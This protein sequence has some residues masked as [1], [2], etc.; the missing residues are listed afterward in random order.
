MAG[1]EQLGTGLTAGGGLPWGDWLSNLYKPRTPALASQTLPPQP[2]PGFQ[3]YGQLPP[4]NAPQDQVN[5]PFGEVKPYQPPPSEAAGDLAASFLRSM[6]MDNYNAAA[7]GRGASNVLLNSPLT[8]VPVGAADFRHHEQTGDK[9][10]AAISAMGV[11]PGGKMLGKAAGEAGSMGLQAFREGAQAFTPLGKSGVPARAAGALPPSTARASLPVETLRPAD[12]V[13]SPAESL[14]TAAKEA[15]TG[16]APAI[17]A[18]TLRDKPLDEAIQIASTEQHLIPKPEGGYVG[19][20]YNVRDTNDIANMRN[21]FDEAVR[22]GASIKGDQWY[23]L[24]RELVEDIAPN[25]PLQ[26][27]QLAQALGL[28]SA[29]AT[30]NTNL[31]FTIQARNAYQVGS[32]AS[33]VRTGAQA[34]KYNTARDTGGDIPLGK[35]TEIYGINLDPNQPWTTTGTNDIWHARAFG[36][37]NPKGKP[38]DSALSAQHHAFLDAETVLAVKRANEM[39]LG[40]R[41]DWTAPEI[42]AASWVGRKAQGLLG[43]KRTPDMPSALA[44]AAQGYTEA[45]P[46]YTAYGTA[47]ATPGKGIGHLESVASGPA[48]LRERFAADP[49]SSYAPGGRDIYHDAAGLYQRDTVPT[50][51]VFEGPAGVEVNP[52]QAA[53]PL[54]SY[55]GKSGERAW[56]KASEQLLRGTEAVKAYVG[57]QRMGAASG[58][59]PTNKAGRSTSFQFPS[60]GQWTPQ[61]VTDVQNIG[62]KYDVPSVVH[63]GDEAV[64]TNW[65]GRPKGFSARDEKALGT[66]LANYLKTQPGQRTEML[67]TSVDY[68]PQWEAGHG[69]GQVT[70]KLREQLNPTMIANLDASPAVRAHVAGLIER[71][72]QFANE[73]GSPQRADLTNARNIIVKEGLAGLFNALDAGKIA[74]PSVAGVLAALPLLRQLSGSQAAPEG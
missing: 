73:T 41:S 71:D 8:S 6:G 33:R 29:Q 35:K 57:A 49:R 20:P 44:E 64:L 13:S 18:T 16:R 12:V 9:T 54:V 55:S 74:L 21:S 25:D 45:L 23:K 50:T 48:A 61:Q 47:E 22:I 63:Y 34:S 5:Q 15:K 3:L 10:N 11:M 36:Y 7:W 69:S 4:F 52:G 40:G 19:A 67:A 14:A 28:F 51:G 42:Q 56:D 39:K 66:D 65:E 58:L 1:E 30:P 60:G 31:G 62:A 68:G 70:A 37:T 17:T 26:Q 38:W 43:K 46:K 24:A 59:V 53:R 72:L 2:P 32:P 27:R